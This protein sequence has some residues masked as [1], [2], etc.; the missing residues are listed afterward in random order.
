[1]HV[2]LSLRARALFIT[3]ALGSMPAL[4]AC[5]PLRLP[6]SAPPTTTS[7][8]SPASTAPLS[9]VVLDEPDPT[10]PTDPT[11]P[12]EASDGH[13]GHMGG[14]PAPEPDEDVSST[15]PIDIEIDDDVPA[16]TTTLPRPPTPGAPPPLDLTSASA[17][18]NP[19]TWGG[20]VPR[21]GADVVVP[22]GRTVLLDTNI[23]VASLRVDGTLVCADRDLSIRARWI[24]VHGGRLTCGTAEA[25]YTKRLDI[26]LVGTASTED[27]MGMGTKFLGSMGGIV[28]FHGRSAPTTWTSLAADAAKGA[29]SISLTQAPPWRAGDRIVIAT[30]SVDQNRF[31][32]ATVA[33]VEGTTVRLAAPLRFPHRG[34]I[35]RAGDVQVEVRAGVG[36]LT[37]NIVIRGDAASASSRFGAHLMFMP[38]GPTSVQLQGVEITDAGQFD[39]LGRYPIHFHQLT[40]GCGACYVRDSSV[41]DTIQ[42]GIVL[43]DTSGIEVRDNVV[44]NT[45]GHNIVVETPA[46]TGNVI[47]H[48]LVLVNRLPSPAFRTPELRD[49]RDA[50]PANF[51]MRSAR[52]TVTRNEAGGSAVAGYFYDQVADGPP[53]FRDNV[54]HGIVG[55]DVTEEFFSGSGLL[56]LMC[57]D[58][59]PA[60]PDFS[61]LLAYDTA[62]S[63][64]W[65]E[66]C[67]LGDDTKQW[68]TGLVSIGNPQGVGVKDS[69]EILV[70]N[71]TFFV[72]E[73]A[74][75]GYANNVLHHQYGGD[76]TLRDIVVVGDPNLMM[77]QNDISHPWHSQ[78]TIGNV[79]VVDGG[80]SPRVPMAMTEY[81]DDSIVPRGFYLDGDQQELTPLGCVPGAVSIEDDTWSFLRCPTRPSFGTL[82]VRPASIVADDEER[83]V[84]GPRGAGTSPM[85]RN[86]GVTT[87]TNP[88]DQPSYWAVIDG[89]MSYTLPTI[90]PAPYTIVRLDR[91]HAE[92]AA[93]GESEPYMVRVTVPADRPPSSVRRPPAGEGTRATDGE[94]PYLP[95]PGS[96]D[97]VAVGSLAALD[98]APL[99]SYLYDAATA[100][101]TLYANVRWLVIER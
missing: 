22:A 4:A 43:H 91:H 65:P 59:M 34:S 8:T 50:L 77:A 14:H 33:S 13:D 84:V 97:L 74:G 37:R 26:T 95:P 5:E 80:V 18:S 17:W 67:F 46:T 42:R 98:A 93:L 3:F 92:F 1:M 81:L 100:T 61:G 35:V 32:V 73:R 28:Q 47:D 52:N 72:G 12:V 55:E 54:V 15:E 60:A 25:P 21:A 29:T 78:F 40:T 39:R 70:T 58:S 44:F 48:N 51:W 68:I 6:T 88:V 89:T 7:T 75:W 87:G 57:R 23:D 71:S 53:D 94:G 82:E 16:P 9:T 2:P 30:S 76:T 64:Y 36:L 66:D 24:M 10:D 11:D 27:V 101:I 62:N 85:V 49:Q 38:G 83:F 45:V 31:D 56:A 96:G 90:D 20:A 86:D 63:G 79:R 69:G 41:H 19:S 99:D